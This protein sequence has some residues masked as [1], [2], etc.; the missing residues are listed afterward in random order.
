MEAGRGGGGVTPR[1]RH[2][3]AWLQGE[4]KKPGF[5]PSS[6]A[7]F[8]YS[9]AKEVPYTLYVHLLLPVWKWVVASVTM[10][11]S[12]VVH[13]QRASYNVVRACALLFWWKIS[14]STAIITP[15]IP[16]G[17]IAIIK[18]YTSRRWCKV[19]INKCLRKKK[20][21]APLKCFSWKDPRERSETKRVN[22]NGTQRTRAK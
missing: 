18:H 12:E 19:M 21:S 5:Y 9:R 1:G 6:T 22:S 16:D 8:S 10:R 11:R 20:K 13:G 17:W 4:N 15:E 3:A 14:Y 7:A 2:G